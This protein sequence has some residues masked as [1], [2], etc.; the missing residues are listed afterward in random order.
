MVA[1]VSDYINA[2]NI[3]SRQSRDIQAA[4]IRSG[5]DLS[6][7]P[8]EAQRQ[9]I[10]TEIEGRK[11]STSV[12]KA[13]MNKDASIKG[14]KM[15]VDKDAR[16]KSKSG[17]RMAG[18]VAAGG[19]LAATAVMGKKKDKKSRSRPKPPEF[20]YSGQLSGIDEQ[21]AASRARTQSLLNPQETADIATA[22]SANPSSLDVS[23]KALRDTISWA[24]GTWDS[25]QGKPMYDVTFGYQKFDNS[26]PHPGTVIHGQNVSS[27]A[28]GA[29]QWMPDTWREMHGG[30]NA[31]MTPANQDAALIRIAKERG[32]YD[33]SKP[34]AEQ[35]SNLAGIWASFPT[36]AGRS[37]Y[38]LDD[39]T[40]QPSRRLQDLVNFYNSREHHY[41]SNI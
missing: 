26:K 30:V 23:Q 11:A 8:Q 13:G 36:K 21:I 15:L 16:S 4:S 37:Q 19:L 3:A 24:E 33:F 2:G 28:H 27:A 20:D 34:F 6:K 22:P 17:S 5:S 1:K 12:A 40:P 25:K 7:I 29:G 9:R 41:N 14:A 39:G 35:A 31:P 32:G 10:L 38:N 18:A